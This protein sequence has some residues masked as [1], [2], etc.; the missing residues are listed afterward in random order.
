MEPILRYCSVEVSFHGHAVTHD[1]SFALQ[2]GEILGIVGESGSGK[3]TLLKAALGLLG[4]GGLVTRG[5]IWFQGKD[6]PDLPERELRRICGGEIGMIFQDAGA[7]LCPVRTIGDQMAESMAAHRK[8]TRAQAKEKALSL[9]EALQLKDG[10]RIWESYPFE[11]S[12]GMQQRVGIAIAMCMNP[13][14]LLADEPTS[15]L[16][17]SVQKQVVEELLRLRRLF[18]TAVVLVS[19]DIGVVSAMADS[20]LVLKEGNVMEY[21]PARQILQEPQNSYTRALLAAVPRLRRA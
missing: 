20:I 10:A 4:T 7:S 8:I 2:K 5:D 11:L 17:A 18:G 21:G 16:D 13:P 12:G 6:L 14:V 3:S 19:H 1:V 15:A 9:F